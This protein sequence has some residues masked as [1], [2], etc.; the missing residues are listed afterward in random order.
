MDP[1]A[2][3]WTLIAACFGFL[4]LFLLLPL[5]AVFVNALGRGVEVYLRALTDPEALSAIRLTLLTAGIAVPLN[6][7]FRNRRRLVHCAL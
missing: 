7:V 1:P 5:A 6:L 3:R 2:V 4:G